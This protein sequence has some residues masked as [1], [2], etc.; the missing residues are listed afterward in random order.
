MKQQ[1]GDAAY[2]ASRLERLVRRISEREI[3]IALVL[4]YAETNC[5]N[6]GL[7]GFYDD[8]AEFL[9][10]LADRLGV[11]ENQAFKNKLTRVVRRLV[12]YGVLHARMRGTAKEYYGEPDKQ[13]SYWLKAGKAELILRG[14]T[15]HTMSPENEVAF[16]LRHAYPEPETPNA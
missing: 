3:A 6:F 7:L 2:R 12:N 15:E 13:M 4:E 9:K 10:G 8:D 11:P 1:L 5:I 16:L 14:E